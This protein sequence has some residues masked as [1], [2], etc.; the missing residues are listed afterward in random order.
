MGPRHLLLDGLGSD[1]LDGGW[2]QT[3]V[4]HPVQRRARLVHSFGASGA[5]IDATIRTGSPPRE[6]GVLF[7]DEVPA[8]ALL[9][10]PLHRREAPLPAE[11]TMAEQVSRLD[12]ILAEV[13]DRAEPGELILVSSGVGGNPHARVVDLPV[14]AI[15]AEG[16]NLRVEPGFALCTPANANARPTPGLRAQILDTPGIERILDPTAE[17]AGAWM[18]PADRG[19][20]LLPEPGCRFPGTPPAPTPGGPVLLAFGPRWPGPWPEAVHDWRVA[21]TLLSALGLDRSACFDEPLAGADQLR[22]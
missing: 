13:L 21:P 18:A 2:L 22:S 12:S 6:H 15:E 4:H 20:I 7:A 16:L 14:A 10:E 5:A 8:R 17:S 3:L 11:S 9:A 1:H 19:W